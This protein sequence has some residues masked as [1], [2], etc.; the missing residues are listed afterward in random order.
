M[1]GAPAVVAF[2]PSFDGEAQMDPIRAHLRGRGASLVV[3]S[4]DGMWTFRADDPIEACAIVDPIAVDLDRTSVYVLDARG[5]VRFA[6]EGEPDAA[7]AD[8]LAIA[9]EEMSGNICRCG[10]YPNIVSAIQIARKKVG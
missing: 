7:L 1:R 3:I 10:A 2:V 8:T 5:I 9:L 4:N 6:H